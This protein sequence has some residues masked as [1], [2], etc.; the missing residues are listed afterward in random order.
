[1]AEEITI[2]NYHPGDIEALVDLI[3]EADAVDQQQRA[4]TLAETEHEMSYPTQYPETDCIL[5]LDGDRLAGYSRLFVRPGDG[6]SASTLYCWGVVHPGWRRRG[7]GRRLLER[8]YQ[9]ASEYVPE[10]GA[11]AVYF[12]CNGQDVEEDRRALFEGFG[13]KAVRYWIV[14]DRSLNC[15]LPPVALPAGIRLRTFVPER[16][17]ETVW[18][19]DNT[20]FRDH[21]NATDSTLEEF[22]H[23]LDKPYIR[24]DLWFLAEDEAS[25]KVVGLGLNVI[26]PEH[27]AR[28]GR[29]EGY[30]DT[31][32]VLRAYRRRGLGSALLAKCLHALKEA[33]MDSAAL[34]ADAENP[35]GAIRIYERAGFRVRK[36]G[37]AYQKV[38]RE[39]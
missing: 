4:T 6:Q 38:M 10:L 35:T 20:A 1:M 15:D 11:G 19:V 16:D 8:S 23:W 3:N 36:T 29:Q 32:A 27:I 37:I 9:R 25:G 39:A 21:W 13:L 5:A 31:V 24:P 22:Q 26:D 30:I 17:L 33:G 7:L 14:M 12:Q 28:T 18:R 2:R 34:D